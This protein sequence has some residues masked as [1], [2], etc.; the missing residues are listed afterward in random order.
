MSVQ[1]RSWDDLPENA[2]KYVERVEEV[3]GVDCKYIGVGPGRDAI[4]IRGP[5]V[6]SKNGARAS[7][8]V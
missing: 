7:Q 8:P 6:G 5:Q 3:V 2:R 1:I 4:V